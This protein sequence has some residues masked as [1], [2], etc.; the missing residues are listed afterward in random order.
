MQLGEFH[1]ALVVGAAGEGAVVVKQQPTALVLHDGMMGRPA[2]HRGQNRA[3]ERERAARIVADRVDQLVR[4]AGRVGEVVLAVIGMHPRTFEVSTIL[5]ARQDGPAIPVDD[6]DFA[7]LLLKRQQ[8]AAEPGDAR[9]EGGRVR[10]GSIGIR[11]ERARLPVLQLS[12]QR[13]PKYM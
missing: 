6:G 10:S 2:D 5:V 3:L 8:I 7:R 9:T 13:P 12:A 11:D 4:R 1:A